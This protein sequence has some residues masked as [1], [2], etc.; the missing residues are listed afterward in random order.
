MIVRNEDRVPSLF[1]VLF[2]CT[3]SIAGHDRVALRLNRERTLIPRVGEQLLFRVVA[4][5]I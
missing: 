4:L 5:V 3:L 2:F 1:L